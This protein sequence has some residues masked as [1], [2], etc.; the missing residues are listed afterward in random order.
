MISIQ[1]QDFDQ[2]SQ[3][4]MR[5]FYESYLGYLGVQTNGCNVAPYVANGDFSVQNNAAGVVDFFF[6][7]GNLAFGDIAGAA[8]GNYPSKSFYHGDLYLTTYVTVA[9]AINAIYTLWLTTGANN[10]LTNFLLKQRAAIPAADQSM[11]VNG[12]S[13]FLDQ[14][15]NAFF[16]FLHF[17]VNNPGVQNTTVVCEFLFNGVRVDY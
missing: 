16:N 6:D 8:I 4:K 3:L 15:N 14:L 12:F 13:N 11:N 2:H 1:P 10:N 9:S 17:N 7:I 5:K